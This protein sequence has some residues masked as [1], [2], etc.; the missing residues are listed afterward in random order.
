MIGGARR[1]V[2][3]DGRA[4][5]TLY[6]AYQDRVGGIE[7][8]R[9]KLLARGYDLALLMAGEEL[10]GAAM[11]KRG[12]LHIGVLKAWQRRWATKGFIRQIIEW[13]AESGPVVTGVALGNEQ[14]R[15]LVEGVGF[16]ATERAEH[17]TRYALQA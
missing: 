1:L 5:G 17:G 14:G 15:R 7:L 6:R 16:V 13:A 2:A 10:I 8:E 12:E 11:R 3:D 9:F 4:I